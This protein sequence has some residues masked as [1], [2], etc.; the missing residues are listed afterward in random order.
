VCAHILRGIAQIT[1][2]FP[3]LSQPQREMRVQLWARGMLE[4]LGV[5]LTV[6]GAPPRTGP[7]L[8]VANHVSFLD[9]VVVHAA[10][11]CR[12]VAKANVSRW[13]LIG[14]LATGA[15]TLYLVRESRRDAMR[16]V[17]AM[18]EALGKGD[19]LALFPEGTTGDGS[20]VLP[21][22][23]GLIQAALA[24]GAP[25]QPVALRF[26]EGSANTPSRAATYIGDESLVG[27]IWRALRARSLH[28]VIGFGVPQ[29]ARGRDRRA[30]ARDLH[31][32][33]AAMHQS[34]SPR[35]PLSPNVQKR[36]EEGQYSQ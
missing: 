26:A 32:Q 9:I 21:F 31:A 2:L 36:A 14:T 19:V 29:T 30:W 33:V 3:R 23:A 6:V 27:S 12:F 15:G 25:V 7:V 4:R 22:R 28:A 18:V 24:A 20:T 17:H 16:V 13:P 1:L 35:S 11:Y 8:L 5:E 34:L 10:C